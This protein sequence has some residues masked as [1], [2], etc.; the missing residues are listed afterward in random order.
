MNSDDVLTAIRLTE[1]TLTLD[2]ID[3]ARQLLREHE[4]WVSL[5][6]LTAQVNEVVSTTSIHFQTIS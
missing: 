5:D 1:P 2:T 3:H 4:A 6:L